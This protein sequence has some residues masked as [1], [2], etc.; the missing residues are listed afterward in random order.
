[1][2]P[3]TIDFFACIYFGRVL[4]FSFGMFT[5]MMCDVMQ[6]CLDRRF[7]HNVECGYILIFFLIVFTQAMNDSG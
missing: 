2:W 3:Q 5:G 6:Y 1:M 7:V 4:I